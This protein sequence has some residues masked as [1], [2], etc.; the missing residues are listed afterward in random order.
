MDD[1]L[2]PTIDEGNVAFSDGTD[3]G[4]EGEEGGERRVNA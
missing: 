2:R 3:R 4:Y 1:L